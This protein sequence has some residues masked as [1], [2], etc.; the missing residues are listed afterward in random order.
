LTKDIIYNRAAFNYAT[1]PTFELLG[2]YTNLLTKN[3]QQA[4]GMS[5]LD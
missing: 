5:A 1:T 3:S 4:Q 2:T